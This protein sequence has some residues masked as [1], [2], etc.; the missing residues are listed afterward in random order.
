MPTLDLSV[1]IITLDEAA[2][3]SRC[4]SSLP[5]GCEI[6]VVDSLSTDRTVE[7]ARAAG[8]LIIERPFTNYSEQKNVAIG[9]ATRRWVLSLDADEVLHV[10]LRDA[11]VTIVEGTSAQSGP[12]A[13]RVRRKL[14]FMNRVMRFGKTTDRPV[15]LFRR[16]EARF[17]SPIHERLTFKG[18]P[19][20]IGAGFLYHYSYRDLEDYFARFN[21]YTTRIAAN[22]AES[23]RGI[24]VL[25]HLLR[26]W[27]EFFYRYVIRLG[28][29]DGYAGYT[30]ALNSSLYAY[31]KYAKAREASHASSEPPQ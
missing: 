6:I 7:I 29:L 19:G 3:L 21:L 1:A 9:A 18:R 14:V 23:G 12:V 4:L 10:A 11:I 8:A 15:R 28:C 27:A 25:G 24:S 17:E 22:H 26:P 16:G 20:S 31:I 13:Y 5:P 2:N 30:Y